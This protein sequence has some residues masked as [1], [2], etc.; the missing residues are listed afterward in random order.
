MLSFFVSNKF[1]A[2]MAGLA[3]AALL[4]IA[5]WAGPAASS[6]NRTLAELVDRANTLDQTVRSGNI[7]D[8]RW[9]RQ[10]EEQQKLYR[11]AEKAVD[12]LYAERDRLLERLFDDPD[13]PGATPPLDEGK[14]KIVYVRKMQGLL[15][16]LEKTVLRTGPGP[17]VREKLPPRWLSSE[18]MRAI[19]KK[20]WVQEAVVSILEDLNKT[21][22][23]VPVFL[24]F[25]FGERPARLLHASHWKFGEIPRRRQGTITRSAPRAVRQPP[26]GGEPT[27][28]PGT[29]MVPPTTDGSSEPPEAQKTPASRPEDKK[30]HFIPVEIQVAMEFE[31]LPQFLKQVLDHPIGM[32]LTEISVTRRAGIQRS[33]RSSLV[34]PRITRSFEESSAVGGPRPPT[35]AEDGRTPGSV[36]ELPA[37]STASAEREKTLQEF[38]K[39][40]VE[41][42]IRAYV[43][44]YLNP[45]K[46]PEKEKAPGSA[47]ENARRR[48]DSAVA[49]GA[50]LSP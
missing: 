2:G 48:P 47:R 39:T 36:E 21:R 12:T 22:I 31:N 19:E 6:N 24:S 25:R 10:A 29:L 28:G 1:W 4:L 33:V 15:E 18:E 7:K 9:V 27:P 40:L 13:D 26:P 45:E 30:F 49:H 17:L 44:D 8:N 37:E 11:S 41:V 16:R 34:G 42:Q 5:L 50:G 46:T 14:W 20:Y 43:V 23:V 35:V 3:I 32:E 38:S